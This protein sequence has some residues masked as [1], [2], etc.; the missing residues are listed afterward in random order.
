MTA[1][2][3]GYNL[4]EITIVL[5][6]VLMMSSFLAAVYFQFEEDGRNEQTARQVEL[7][8]ESIVDYAAANKTAVRYVDAINLSVD[9][10]TTVTSA[11]T[12]RWTL[13]AGRPYLPCPDIDGD[14]LE[15]RKPPLPPFSAIT[16]TTTVPV[17]SASYPLEING[18]CIS[19]RGI[20]PWRT[21]KTPGADPWGQRYTFRSAGI[22]SNSMT[23]FDQHTRANSVYKSRPLT[24]SASGVLGFGATFDR[25][26][27][28]ASSISLT[29]IPIVNARQY[30][31]PAVI[32][33]YESSTVAADVR[34][35]VG[36]LAPSF[37]ALGG[38]PV[39]VVEPNFAGPRFDAALTSR[40]GRPQIVSGVPFVVVSHGKNGYGGVRADEG[41]GGYFC[42][43]FP[44]ATA[45]T[46]AGFPEGVN[47]DERVNA[48][49]AVAIGQPGGTYNCPA[50]DFAVSGRVVVYLEISFIPGI[51]YG[52]HSG[53]TE[54]LGGYDDI[55]GWMTMPELVSELTER[56]AL[57]AQLWPPIGLER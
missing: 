3:R 11:I 6:V 19:S 30:F 47:F 5:T 13:P 38:A 12:V 34:E 46:T 9:V 18:G 21:L 57:P 52:S 54:V 10:V 7:I 36:E 28:V 48:Y 20:L 33:T 4:V 22:F 44:D 15:D 56:G 49:R 26:A 8:K 29:G 31:S 41:G 40:L 1:R 37:V 43:P 27:H 16:I 32:L 42:R 2:Q 53:R 51:N 55:V 50:T 24:L 23:G 35:F 25:A 14:G 39:T 17:V 45:I